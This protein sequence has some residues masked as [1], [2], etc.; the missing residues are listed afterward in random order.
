MERNTKL[1]ACIAILLASTFFF[2]VTILQQNQSVLLSDE[3]DNEA[4]VKLALNEDVKI[5]LTGNNSIT[6]DG[7]FFSR[8][9]ISEE[10]I[11]L[12]LSKVY[13]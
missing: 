7:I 2:S 13:P 6:R 8:L 11:F 1:V 5:M 9:R 4:L 12:M 10:R 3:S